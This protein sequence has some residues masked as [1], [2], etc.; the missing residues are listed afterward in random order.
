MK[1]KFFL[2]AVLAA[3]FFASCES[4][5]DNLP[6][7]P[8]EEQGNYTEGVFILNEGNFGSGNSTVSFLDAELQEIQQDIFAQENDE[9][10]L[11]D[12]GQSMVIFEDLAF[13]VMNVSNTIQVVNRH[14]FEHERTIDSGLHNPRHIAVSGG[15]LFVTNWGD[16][17]DPDDD[18]VAVFNA[19]DLDFEEK[20]QVEEGPEK[21]IEAAGNI[22]VAHQGG[23]NFNDKISV[24]DPENN[25]VEELITVG[26]VPNSLAS[27][28]NFLWVGSAGL[29]AYSDNETGGEF[30]K[31]DLV[32]HEIL[33]EYSFEDNEHP[34]NLSLVDGQ[35]Y[36]TLENSVYSF[37]ENESTLPENAFIDLVDAQVLYG[38]EVIGELI[39]AASASSD[40][41]SN[42]EVLIYDTGNG[43][44]ISS[45]ET[46]INPNGIYHNP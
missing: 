13:I 18:F 32:T 22:Y 4:D 35:V 28:G 6:E 12:T 44:L 31:I 10:T 29:P 17:E 23:Y 15:K 2:P 41:T 34:D 36:Y 37:S 1:I 16:G 33:E 39:F 19:A 40:F 43:S 38:F 9:E 14:T 30:L 24:I 45:F 8:E 11:G 5:D 20:I 46:G 7:T 27:D 26:D 25:S 21:L 3:F 42:G